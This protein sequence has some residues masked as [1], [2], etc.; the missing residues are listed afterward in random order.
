MHNN[1]NNSNNKNGA[2][3]LAYMVYYLRNTPVGYGLF[4]LTNALNNVSL[5]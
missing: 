5:M 2:D 1:Q 3:F 4:V